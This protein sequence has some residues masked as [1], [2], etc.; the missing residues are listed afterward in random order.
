MIQMSE[1]HSC[2]PRPIYGG[3]APY[4]IGYQK[5]NNGLFWTILRPIINGWNL[6]KNNPKGWGLDEA[7]PAGI[8]MRGRK[9]RR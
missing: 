9:I 3:S 7:V 4:V 8:G 2:E 5:D 1:E 6:E